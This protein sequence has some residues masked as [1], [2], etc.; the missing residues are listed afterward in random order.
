[1]EQL[2]KELKATGEYS[3]EYRLA[4]KT[5][6]KYLWMGEKRLNPVEFEKYQ[7][8]IALF[9]F[10]EELHDSIESCRLA[11]EKRDYPLF[12]LWLNGQLDGRKKPFHSYALRLDLILR[13]SRIPFYSILVMVY[14][15]DRSTG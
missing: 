3:K 9:P 10:L 7:A 8:C 15:K 11:I 12:L 14:S 2:R 6:V 13:L 5:L 4:R 1:V